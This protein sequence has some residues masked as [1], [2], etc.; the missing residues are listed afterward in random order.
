MA[1]YGCN[2][3]LL[4]YL[5]I[6]YSGSLDISFFEYLAG[7]ELCTYEELLSDVLHCTSLLW[8]QPKFSLP[9]INASQ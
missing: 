3:T 1:T 6:E 4:G 8:L 7:T 5:E 2:G 9:I